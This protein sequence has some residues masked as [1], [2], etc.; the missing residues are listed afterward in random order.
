MLL[1]FF[2]FNVQFTV[3]CVAVGTLWMNGVV[4]LKTN[5]IIFAL[6]MYNTSDFIVLN[7]NISV[8]LRIIFLVL[9]CCWLGARHGRSLR[10]VTN[11]RTLLQVAYGA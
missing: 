8:A 2:F 7:N 9:R 1:M 11:I 10:T 6:L 4:L 3:D 5:C